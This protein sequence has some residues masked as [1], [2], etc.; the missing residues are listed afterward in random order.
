MKEG[1]CEPSQTGLLLEPYQHTVSL[2]F[3]NY[4]TILKATYD[5]GTELH[6]PQVSHI[7]IA[8][9]VLSCVQQSWLVCQH[10][11]IMR[12]LCLHPTKTYRWRTTTIHHRCLMW[13]LFLAFVFTQNLWQYAI[14]MLRTLT[15]HW[16]K[17]N[18]D[19]L[20][21]KYRPAVAGNRT[22]DTSG[23]SCQYVPSELC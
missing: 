22:Q 15:S 1:L 10:L 23:L 9:E 3:L 20:R 14:R 2:T 17:E 18:L 4:Q 11:V 13:T 6:H 8:M 7:C 19:V 21:Q 16:N 5:S 12:Y